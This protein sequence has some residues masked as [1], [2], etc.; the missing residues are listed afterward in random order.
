MKLFLFG[1]FP[2]SMILQFNLTYSVDSR[3]QV[4]QLVRSFVTTLQFGCFK[5]F[6]SRRGDDYR[7]WLLKVVGN[8]YIGWKTKGRNETLKVYNYANRFLHESYCFVSALII[9]TFALPI[10]ISSLY[11]YIQGQIGSIYVQSTFNKLTFASNSRSNE[12][13]TKAQ[14]P[15]CD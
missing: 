8:T 2:A 9:K 13:C 3:T 4:F 7:L 5:V 15:N 1:S 10:I 6:G 11:I 12:V 14:M